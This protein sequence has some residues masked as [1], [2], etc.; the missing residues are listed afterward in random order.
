MTVTC[1]GCGWSAEVPDEKIPAEG[2]K[3][4]CP[5]CQVKFEV[6]KE[7]KPVP[8]QPPASPR[9]ESRDTKPCPLCG[10]EI[11]AVAKKCKHCGSMLNE[12]NEISPQPVNNVSEDIQSNNFEPNKIEAEAPKSVM[13]QVG[14]KP[15]S[16]TEKVLFIFV[17]LAVIGGISKGD[18]S[19]IGVLILFVIALFYRMRKKD[20]CSTDSQTSS[21]ISQP[22]SSTKI[23]GVNRNLFAIFILIILMSL[24][25][26]YF[27]SS[28]APK[29]L[30]PTSAEIMTKQKAEKEAKHKAEMEAL[31][32]RSKRVS[33]NG[34]RL[35]QETDSMMKPT[36]ED[37]NKRTK[38]Y[39]DLLEK[40]KYVNG[41]K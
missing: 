25:P 2:G 32:E 34:A 11:L 23:F 39:D 14:R 9:S 13:A 1:P 3:G 12:L 38:E 8:E 28:Y 22:S 18:S 41:V 24:L 31:Y 5:K 15:F 20:S 16:N 19:A 35:R 7:L 37:Y 4:T 40:S 6:K 27:N 10:E 36:T 33:E 30:P 21:A 26:L 17:G 29:P